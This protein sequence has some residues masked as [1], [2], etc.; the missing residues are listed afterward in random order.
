MG[1]TANFDPENSTVSPALRIFGLF[2]KGARARMLVNVDNMNTCLVEDSDNPSF[3]MFHMCEST[4]TSK[5]NSQESWE[6]WFVHT[7]G[8]CRFITWNDWRINIF[9]HILHQMNQQETVTYLTGIFFSFLR[10]NSVWCFACT[11][12]LNYDWTGNIQVLKAEC[13]MSILTYCCLYIERD[14]RGWLQRQ[15]Y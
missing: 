2:F 11:G 12:Y 5:P 13:I 9:G 8:T 6:I 10:M 3:S 4:Q 1:V 14:A 15:K 7:L